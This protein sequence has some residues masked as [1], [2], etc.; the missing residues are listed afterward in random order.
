MSHCP[1]LAPLGKG[2]A[3]TLPTPHWRAVP[4]PKV[5]YCSSVQ[6]LPRRP[7][8]RNRQTELSNSPL[9]IP[10]GQRL[11]LEHLNRTQEASM[12]E[13][14]AKQEA[15]AAAAACRIPCRLKPTVPCGGDDGSKIATGRSSIAAKDWL[16]AGAWRC[17]IVM[18]GLA[19]A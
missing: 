3:C 19:L 12:R 5:V 15:K 6:F 14:R 13:A 7:I 11:Q 18:I 4:G 1:T 10:G 8:R 16:V 17:F 2:C 9:D